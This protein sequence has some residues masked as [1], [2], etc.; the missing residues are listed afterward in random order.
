M[1][2]DDLRSRADLV[3]IARQYGVELQREG[4]EWVACCPLPDHDDDT[5][6]WKIFQAKRGGQMWHC[7]GCGQQGDVIDLV[8]LVEGLET[9]RAAMDR[10]EEMLGGTAAPPAVGDRPAP[11]A[12]KPTRKT[13]RGRELGRWNYPNAEGVVVLQVRKYEK[14]WADTGERVVGEDGHPR[15]DFLQFSPDGNGGWKATSIDAER[16]V[17]YQLP[18]VL[19][20]DTVWMVEGEKDADS[21]TRVGITATTIPGGARAKWSPNYT[22]ALRGKYVVICPDT[23]Q[24]GQEHGARCAHELRDAAASLRICRLPEL[25]RDVTEFLEAGQ[26]RADLEAMVEPLELPPAEEPERPRVTEMPSPAGQQAKTKPAAVTVEGEPVG[27][28]RSFLLYKSDGYTPKPLFAN[29]VTAFRMAPEWQGKLWWDEFALRTVFR[30]ARTPWGSGGDADLIWSDQETNLATEWL[31][32]EAAVMVNSNVV[33]QAIQTVAR[34][35]CFH[36]VRD[37]LNFLVWDGMPRLDTWLTEYMH[38]QPSNYTAAAGAAW[39]ISAV[40]RVM[41]PGSK[42]DTAIVFEGEQG[43]GKSTT[44]RA[45][46]EPWFSDDMAEMGTKDAAI[47][48]AGVWILELGELSSMR[49]TMVEKVKAFMTRQTDRYRPP[50]GKIAEEFHRQCVFAAS[51]NEDAWGPDPTGARRFWPIRCGDDVDVTRIREDR[52]Q[53]W[54]EAVLRFKEGE[55]WYLTDEA[56]K[57]EAK[58][59]QMERYQGDAWDDLILDWVEKPEQSVDQHGHPVGTFDSV[60]GSISITD[61][62]QHCIRKPQAQWTQGD[63][64]RVQK[65]LVA[66]GY[67]R[68]KVGTREARSWRYVR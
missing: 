13:K 64:L 11:A 40:A 50:Y 4:S 26:T 18:A 48:L 47:Q 65:C 6:S 66:A 33:G 57:A 28:W 37:Y 44:L 30:G 67:R 16:R 23:N 32:R 34:E 15:K 53:L 68:R 21:L 63:R 24:P 20:S 35:R 42:V 60:A 8:R 2:S 39:M 61:V 31:Q 22:E 58:A 1:R 54:A 55:R 5:P 43:V 29:A 52:D 46:G 17:L 9:P 12:K 36:P 62:L 10:L 27:D 41:R 59:E 3:A 7:F 25:V 38:A 45:L 56:I 49:N 51:T 19:A 14:L